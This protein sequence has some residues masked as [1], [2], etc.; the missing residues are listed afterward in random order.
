MKMD[1]FEEAMEKMSQM[2]EEQ[3]KALIDMEKKK[4]CICRNCTSFNQCTDENKEALFCI[5]GKSDCE[6][7]I[8]NCIC[9]E[10]PAHT[11]FQMKHDSYCSNGSE[12]D[13]REKET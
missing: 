6:L 9:Q 12:E 7:E 8:T 4:I 13:Q 5:L 1:K 11:N 3:Y 2:P 10:C